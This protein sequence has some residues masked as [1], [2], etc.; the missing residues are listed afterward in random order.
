[1]T[2]LTKRNNNTPSGRGFRLDKT[3]GKIFGVCGGIANA[4][5]IDA[6]WIRLGLV[7]VTL[8]LTGLTI[9][10]YIVAALIAD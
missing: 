2:N 7:I 9:P 8:A 5:G 3:N 4:T 1:M 10:V 6:L